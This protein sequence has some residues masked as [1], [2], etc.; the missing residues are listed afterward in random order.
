MNAPPA[1]PGTVGG[2]LCHDAPM[3]LGIQEIVRRLGYHRATPTTAPIFEHNRHLAIE[4]AMEWD[5]TLPEGREKACA[6]TSLQ[7]ALMWANAAVACNSGPGE[8]PLPHDMPP[9]YG[10]PAPTPDAIP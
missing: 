5:E 2:V 1:G 7:E 9:G 4:L 6:Q 8:D 3:A 10:E